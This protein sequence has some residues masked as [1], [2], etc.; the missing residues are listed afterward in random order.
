MRL[1]G[2]Q[3]ERGAAMVEA[4]VAI[5][6]FLV[7]FAAAIFVL[8]LYGH[9]AN[10][11]AEA[12]YAVWAY[13]LNSCE[14]G[15]YTT[16]A[17]T[18]ASGDDPP[19]LDA[20]QNEESYPETGELPQEGDDLIANANDD[21]NTDLEIG[22]DWGVAR[23]SVS[24]GPVIAPPPLVGMGRDSVTTTMEVQCDEKP[25]GASP[26]DVLSFVWNLPST[27]NLSN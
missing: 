8:R 27:V 5:P 10:S 12:R 21:P 19:T 7:L 17:S 9:K 20:V 6:L 3:R 1:A 25:R 15:Q 18:S 24:R 14:E 11:R 22:D 13:A 26:G 2:K 23:A 4:V 16:S